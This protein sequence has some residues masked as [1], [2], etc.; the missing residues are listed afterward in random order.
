M[1]CNGL[2]MNYR[3]LLCPAPDISTEHLTGPSQKA[4]NLQNEQATRQMNQKQIK[5]QSKNDIYWFLSW[6][7]QILTYTRGR[8]HAL[9]LLTPMWQLSPNVISMTTD[10]EPVV[11]LN[12]HSSMSRGSARWDYVCKERLNAYSRNANLKENIHNIYSMNGIIFILI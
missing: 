3:A 4:D 8:K 11:N 5:R 12:W 7:I 2:L 1:D 9:V 6:Q 10:L